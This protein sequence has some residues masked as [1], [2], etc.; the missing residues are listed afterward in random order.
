MVDG[1]LKAYVPWDDVQHDVRTLAK[2][3]GGP[4]SIN[5]IG[6]D[7][8][9]WGL[10]IS[11]KGV[12]IGM[13]LVRGILGLLTTLPTGGI[14]EVRKTDWSHVDFVW[15]ADEGVSR[16]NMAALATFGM[17][18]IGS[19]KNV[20]SVAISIDKEAFF[21]ETSRQMSEWRAQMNP[22]IEEHY[23]L[24][25]KIHLNTDFPGHEF[26][27]S[28]GSTVG[29]ALR[30]LEALRAEGLLTETEYQQKRKEILARL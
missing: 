25:S 12:C 24:K 4:E 19:R 23:Q 8:L 27:P 28:S 11:E 13:G 18:A 26:D 20:T 2:F 16:V 30:N 1:A 7:R 29:E 3:K 17:L 15:I 21:F 9:R 5:S 22:L 14:A 10:Q 6:F